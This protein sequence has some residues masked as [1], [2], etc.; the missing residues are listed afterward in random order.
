MKDTQDTSFIHIYRNSEVY[1][2]LAIDLVILSHTRLAH[3][4]PEI[5]RRQ[6]LIV[7]YADSYFSRPKPLIMQEDTELLC[8]TFIVL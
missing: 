6:I 3:G 5:L 2:N 7:L 4:L 8:R 1:F